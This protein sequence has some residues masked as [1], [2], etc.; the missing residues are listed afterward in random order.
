MFVVFSV[1]MLSD[2]LF[3]INAIKGIN[4]CITNFGRILFCELWLKLFIIFQGSKGKRV[5]EAKY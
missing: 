1:N 5:V 4:Y 2:P 3:S